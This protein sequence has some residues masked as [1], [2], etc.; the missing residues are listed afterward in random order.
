MVKSMSKDSQ[1]ILNM[2]RVQDSMNA[3]L[4]DVGTDKEVAKNQAKVDLLTFYITKLYALR[5]A[6]SGKTKKALTTFNL[7]E[8]DANIIMSAIFYCYPTVSNLEIVKVARVLADV[9]M[10]DELTA[11]YD[12]CIK[13]SP[14]YNG[15]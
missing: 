10:R 12:V 8:F 11:R 13:E 7:T 2:M 3:V 14:N 4:G 1:I 5:K 9:A 6:V 15:E